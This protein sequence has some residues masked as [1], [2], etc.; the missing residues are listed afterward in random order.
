MTITSPKSVAWSSLPRVVIVNWVRWPGT[1][2]DW[3]TLPAAT[4]RFC[5]RRAAATSP[6]LRPRIASFSGS[7]QIRML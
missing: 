3:P 4:W 2:G 1:V 6:A 5:S 7:S